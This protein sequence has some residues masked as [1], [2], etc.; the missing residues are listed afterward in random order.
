MSTELLGGVLAVWMVAGLVAAVMAALDIRAERRVP[1]RVLRSGRSGGG[2]W[3]VL[4]G[5]DG[6]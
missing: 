4:V 1:P 3:D 6:P 5:I 2:Q